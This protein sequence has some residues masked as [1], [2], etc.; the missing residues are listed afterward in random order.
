MALPMLSKNRYGTIVDS[1]AYSLWNE[2][3]SRR[4]VSR[5]QGLDEWLYNLVHAIGEPYANVIL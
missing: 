2:E 5:F 4:A 3:L 1:K